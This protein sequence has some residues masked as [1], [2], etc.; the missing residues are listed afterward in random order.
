MP[1]RSQYGLKR[2][3]SIELSSA[4]RRWVLPFC[5]VLGGR[6]SWGPAGPRGVGLGGLTRKSS[7]VPGTTAQTRRM[8]PSAVMMLF[9]VP[10]PMSRKGLGSG[11]G[12]R[13]SGSEPRLAPGHA[14][15]HAP[16]RGPRPWKRLPLG[17]T[18][19]ARDAGDAGSGSIPPSRRLDGMDTHLARGGTSRRSAVS[20]C[21]R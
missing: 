16:Q 15:G 5:Q 14:P 1:L 17:E 3:R 10:S 20:S 11:S 12:R 4:S 8:M 7:S 21:P 19:D 6:D 2:V 18:Q 13:E 9:F